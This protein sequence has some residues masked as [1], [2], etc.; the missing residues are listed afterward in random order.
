M[1]LDGEEP[2]WVG[3]GS[4]RAAGKLSLEYEARG[5]WPRAGCCWDFEVEEVEGTWVKET[6]VRSSMGLINE[7]VHNTGRF[8]ENRYGKN[9]LRPDTSNV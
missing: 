7:L 6:P 1:E 5:F 3:A 9:G 4:G 8:G 2:F